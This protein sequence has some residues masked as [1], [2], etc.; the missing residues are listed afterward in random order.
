MLQRSPNRRSIIVQWRIAYT[1]LRT[2]KIWQDMRKHS[3]DKPF[4]C[5]KCSKTF[6]LYD[7]LKTH[8]ITHEGIRPYKCNVCTYASV[9]SG[10]LRK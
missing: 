7:K 4:E 6:S 5:K 10:S 1:Q 9:D 8:L 3:G 2:L